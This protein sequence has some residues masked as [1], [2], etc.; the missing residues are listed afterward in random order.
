MSES[1]Y[2]LYVG[3][4]GCA[5]VTVAAAMNAF[6][7]SFIC[8]ECRQVLRKQ[9][10]TFRPASK[11]HGS[12]TPSSTAFAKRP[13]RVGVIGSGPAGFYAAARILQKSDTAHVD[14]FEKLPVPFGLVRYG[15][16]PDHPEV[17]V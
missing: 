12:S 1:L 2:S 16:A 4:L 17:K 6:G 15:V 7:S 5:R 13:L 14:M 10:R 11:R 8:Y 9:H 3:V